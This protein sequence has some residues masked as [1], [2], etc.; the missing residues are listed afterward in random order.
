[1]ILPFH[2]NPHGKIVDIASKYI[3][4]PSEKD[5]Y[6]VSGSAINNKGIKLTPEW[7]ASG[8]NEYVRVLRDFGS[9]LYI[10]EEKHE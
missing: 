4:M 7:S 10:I 6:E 9:R 1:M 2:V 8:T 5:H 3:T